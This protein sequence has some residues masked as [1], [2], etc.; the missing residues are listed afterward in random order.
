MKKLV[1]LLLLTFISCSPDDM[2]ESEIMHLPQSPSGATYISTTV[3]RQ[4][5]LLKKYYVYITG[6]T[7]KRY[8][9]NISSSPVDV[10]VKE[11][12]YGKVLV[13]QFMVY[14]EN[15]YLLFSAK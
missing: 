12:D 9:F 4:G 5:T 7:M 13:G 2:A 8:Y 10:E 14:Q 15:P 11:S 1:A 6:T 3:N